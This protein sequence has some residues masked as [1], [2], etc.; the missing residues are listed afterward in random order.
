[1]ELIDQAAY[2]YLSLQFKHDILIGATAIGWTQHIGVLRG[3]IQGKVRLGSQK[4]ALME[5]PTR[6]MA[7]YLEAIQAVA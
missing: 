5:D 1:M 6:F 4:Q 7:S 2:H 3:L